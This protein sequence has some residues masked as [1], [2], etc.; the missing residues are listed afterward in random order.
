[1][2]SQIDIFLSTAL[3]YEQRISQWP[4]HIRL[5]IPISSLSQ[6]NNH[7]TPPNLSYCSSNIITTRK[8]LNWQNQ[9][10][11]WPIQGEKSSPSQYQQRLQMRRPS[12]YPHRSHVHT[13]TYPVKAGHRCGADVGILLRCFELGFQAVNQIDACKGLF[14]L[15]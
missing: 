8:R 12:F 5:P 4:S 9:I 13:R 10:Q 3:M 7:K 2:R 1:M 11:S 6:L 15:D 14:E